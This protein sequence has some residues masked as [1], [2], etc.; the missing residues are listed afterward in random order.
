[1]TWSNKTRSKVSRSDWFNHLL[2]SYWILWSCYTRQRSF[3]VIW[4]PRTSYWK[5]KFSCQM[6]AYFY[7]WSYFIQITFIQNQS[8]RLWISLPRNESNV[9]LYPITVLSVTWSSSWLGLLSGHWYVVVWMHSTRTIPWI[10]YLS[11]Y[12]WIQPTIE[13]CRYSRVSLPLFRTT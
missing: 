12:F 4:N 10:T 6:Y 7:W 11:G 3:T 9:H 8:D 5:R 2:C 1:M 13:N